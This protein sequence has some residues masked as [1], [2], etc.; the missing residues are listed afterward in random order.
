MHNARRQQEVGN[1]RMNRIITE[2]VRSKHPEVYDEAKAVYTKLDMLY[3]TK[4]D[5]RKTY[6]FCVY[7]TGSKDNKYKYSRKLHHQV[8]DNFVL[9]IP[10]MDTSDAPTV[11]SDIPPAVIPPADI[12][13]AV[14]PPAV[15]PPAD[16]P[17]AVIP[18]A[19]IPPAVIPPA[20]IPPDVGAEVTLPFL[21][22]EIIDEIIED[23]RNDPE[24]NTFF[25]QILT[26]GETPLEEELATLGF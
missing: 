16:I 19:V 26:T 18:P 25:D 21:S 17:P 15:I 13:P 2:Y 12:P 10:L 22:N 4:K 8:S 5:L 23:L 3:P 24:I 9:E 20:V 7:T 6:E 1:I 14:I 11:A